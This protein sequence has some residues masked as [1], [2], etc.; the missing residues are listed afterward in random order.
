MKIKYV[1]KNGE[2]IYFEIKDENINFDN[3]FYSCLD[4]GNGFFPTGNGFI[5]KDQIAKIEVVE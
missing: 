1:L 5:A 2:I 4:Y 3:W